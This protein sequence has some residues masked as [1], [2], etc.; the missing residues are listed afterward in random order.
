[1]RVWNLPYN[2]HQDRL[3]IKGRRRNL[4][5][6]DRNASMYEIRQ[7]CNRPSNPQNTTAETCPPDGWLGA[8]QPWRRSINRQRRHSRWLGNLHPLLERLASRGIMGANIGPALNPSMRQCCDSPS[9]VKWVLD[10]APHYTG[11][12][13]PLSNIYTSD[14]CCFSSLEQHIISC[15]MRAALAT[16]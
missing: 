4:R 16:Q 7:A 13:Q 12:H 10:S 15:V 3:I 5:V 8:S 11:R 6:F 9:G 2:F 1:M 14:R